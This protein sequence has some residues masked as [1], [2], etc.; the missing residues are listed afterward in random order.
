M[1]DSNTANGSTTGPVSYVNTLTDTHRHIYD[2]SEIYDPDAT[3]PPATARYIPPV[4][5]LV[6]ENNV[7]YKVTAV[8][9]RSK[10]T[11]VPA[12]AAGLQESQD[13]VTDHRNDILRLFVNAMAS[14]IRA[15]VDMSVRIWNSNAKTYCLYRYPGQS[16]Q[17]IISS[18]YDSTLS[19]DTSYPP[20][21]VAPDNSAS[22]V[23]AACELTTDLT[24]NEAIGVAIFDE[25]GAEIYYTILN[26]K[27]STVVNDPTT[28]TQQIVSLAVKSAQMTSD[29]TCYLY[30][31]QPITSLDVY[32]VLTFSDG[33]TKKILVDNR[34]TFL[35]GE[36]DFVPSFTGMKQLMQMRYN[37]A[38]NETTTSGS[39]TSAVSI[40]EDFYVKT[41][42][43][44]FSVP[45]KISVLPYFDP[46]SNGYLLKY[47]LYTTTNQ[48]TDI[49]SQ[50][51]LP[52]TAFQPQNFVN[53]QNL[54]L[55]VDLSKIG[56]S[57]YTSTT[58]KLQTVV[59]K[60]GMPTAYVRYT[61]TDSL[62]SPNTYGVDSP[63]Q[64][65]PVLYYDATK[66]V[67]FVPSSIF[68]SQQG[69][70][71]SFFYAATPL[72]DS[73]VTTE[74]TT[75]DTFGIRDPNSMLLLSQ[76]AVSSYA[77]SITLSKSKNYIGST[78]IVEFS[79]TNGSGQTI[80]YGVPVDVY[81]GS[82]TG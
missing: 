36:T 45:S 43:G 80:L 68:Q 8:D 44:Q 20:I 54:T 62:S 55:S 74:V 64:R 1:S 63:T 73:R 65:R 40:S 51:T 53:P 39:N 75:P 15:S 37:L 11:L 27:H 58:I 21:V 57:S 16:T 25:T 3:N 82:Y 35:Y 2:I 23:C 4:G 78:V 19:Q 67:Y 6:W 17:T 31:N 14:P 60:L 32:G 5:S 81:A 48:V 10:S 69:F 76:T 70:L 34:Q 7:P 46:N 41:L 42:T 33:T 18:Y 50:V 61:I 26:A 72:Y 28:N 22:Y 9:S 79:V 59:I 30:E 66:G 47:F 12:F 38:P 49:T 13:G 29:G 24:D 52:D 71:N 77:T 56:D